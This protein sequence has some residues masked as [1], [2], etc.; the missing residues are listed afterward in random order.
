MARRAVRGRDK[1]RGWGGPRR[2]LALA[3]LGLALASG[4]G[5]ATVELVAI[6]GCGLDQA[7][8]G[9]RVRV[10]GDLP[11][12]AGTELVL[13]PGEAGALEQ[14][15]AGAT[16]IAAEGL[17][18]TTVTAIG[19]S[20]GADSSRFGDRLGT[21]GAALP[22]WFAAPD[23]LCPIAL[24]DGLAAT[25]GVGLAV[26]PAADLLVVGGVDEQGALLDAAIHVD[27]LRPGS[28]RT[29]ALGLPEALR[30]PIVVAGPG[31]SFTVVGGVGAA[32]PRGRW[33]RVDLG[34]DEAIDDGGALTFDGDPWA[35]A[36]VATAV[37]EGGALLLAG[38]CA[39]TDSAGACVPSSSSDRAGRLAWASGTIEPLPALARA[40]HGAQAAW[41]RD[42]VAWVAGGWDS[43]GVGLGSV[44]RLGPGGE[45]V[46]VHELADATIHGLAVLDGGLVLLADDG[47]AIHWWSEAG[48]GI[49]DPTARAP[50]LDP[51][52][53]ARPMLVLPGERVLVEGWLFSPGSAAIDPALE[54]VMLAAAHP[55]TALALL[56]DGS[57]VLG[58]EA[59]EIGAGVAVERLR[60]RLDGPD[61]WIPD[62]TGPQTDAF[63]ATAPGSS[64]VGVGGL[65]ISAAG[66]DADLD[67]VAAAR[68][69]VR[70][71]RSASVRLEL[72]HES[73]AG[74]VAQLIVGQGSQTLVAVDLDGSAPGTVRARG[75]DGAVET[76]DCER[77][78]GTLAGPLIVEL[79]EGGAQLSI[80]ASGGRAL[81]CALD[82]PTA[83]ELYLGFGAAGT[84]SA[85]FFGL[86][87]AR[88]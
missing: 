32:G 77:G 56:V 82:W 50:A 57:V 58:R 30:D 26:G 62:L 42:G 46:V 60:P 15:P 78:P 81:A 49:L 35:L 29:L 13:G 7:F 6:R 48:A 85:R 80:E 76:L 54:R 47:G 43:D 41:S 40:R 87:L 53:V 39:A 36:G 70:G 52:S 14:L 17:F 71:F 72:E 22:V 59:V 1:R 5:P 12:G 66:A 18:G 31:R 33:A 65:R 4:C 88:R 27:L 51:T 3:P 75:P 84:G 74:A 68:A 79:G 20:W 83:A 38:G 8:S 86:R 73:E 19:R 9:L 55:N 21:E 16:G 64:L 44:E 23:S 61:E 2:R 63:V 37:G 10:L 69:H 25:A 11:V 45:W 24:P 67:G 28:A 34:R